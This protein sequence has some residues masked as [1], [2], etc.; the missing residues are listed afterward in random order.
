MTHA[1][2]R[3]LWLA[4]LWCPVVLSAATDR[5][6]SKEGTLLYTCDSAFLFALSGEAKVEE[7]YDWV[8]R[9]RKHGGVDVYSHMVFHQGWVELFQSEFAEHDTRQKYRRL[10]SI[11]AAGIQPLNLFIDRAHKNGM[12]FLAGVRINDDQVT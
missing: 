6:A 3:T 1:L 11:F 10:N 9:Q 2:H 12:K 8:D 5:A 4:C 7:I